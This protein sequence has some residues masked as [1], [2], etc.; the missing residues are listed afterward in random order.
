MIFWFE[1]EIFVQTIGV[2]EMF[3]HPDYNP[4]NLRND[5]AILKLKEEIKFTDNVKP[6]CLPVDISKV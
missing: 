3:D 1:Q 5:I 4:K 6:A 2:E